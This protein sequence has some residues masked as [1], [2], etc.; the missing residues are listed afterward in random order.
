MKISFRDFGIAFPLYEAHV[1][2]ED[3][4]DYA[5]LGTCCLC[6]TAN[7]PCFHLGIPADLILPCPSCGQ[8]NSLDVHDKRSGVCRDCRAEILFP[9]EVAAKKEPK[10]CFTCLRAGKAA[11]SK[12]TELGMVDAESLVTGLTNGVP[13]L[14]QAE[15]ESVVVDEGDSEDDD[16]KWIKVRLPAEII[17][18][19]LRT[20]TYGTWQGECWLFCCRYAMTFVGEWKHTDF[21]ARA[22]DGDGEKL[23]N[24]LEEVPEGGWDKL[25]RSFAVYVFECKRCGKLRSHYDSD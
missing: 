6:R 15:F 2:A 18:E 22:S 1:S 5:G 9:P 8:S 11:I 13:G 12:D 21:D 10:I 16:E 7:A 23:Y 24:S 20:P 25:G 3:D 19:L 14:E 4:S 17:T